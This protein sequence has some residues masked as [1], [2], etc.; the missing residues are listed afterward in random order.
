MLD[1]TSKE[2]LNPYS[3]S[4]SNYGYN[5]HGPEPTNYIEAMSSN[6][7]VSGI[8]MCLSNVTRIGDQENFPIQEGGAELG[9]VYNSNAGE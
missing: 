3:K 9:K 7:R 5:G 8:N 4:G 2:M 6:Q 1:K